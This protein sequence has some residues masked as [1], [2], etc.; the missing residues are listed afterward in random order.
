MAS[1]IQILGAFLVSLGVSF[2]FPPAGL[3]VA[4]ALAIVFGISLEKK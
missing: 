2:V 3:V 4:G 1:S